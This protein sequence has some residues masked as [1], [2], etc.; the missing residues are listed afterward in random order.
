MARYVYKRYT[1]KTDG[2][3]FIESV[4]MNEDD[5]RVRQGS[6]S[7]QSF[8]DLI[9]QWNAVAARGMRPGIPIN[10]YTVET[11]EH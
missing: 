3:V 6:A 11:V 7:E 5:L 9:N 2:H 10:V 1:L 8:H 4:A